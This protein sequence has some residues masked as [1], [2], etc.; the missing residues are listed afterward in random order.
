[1]F[2]LVGMMGACRKKREK[3][4]CLLHGPLFVG[5]GIKL[6]A[7]CCWVT[8]GDFP[9]DSALLWVGNIMT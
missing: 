6:D 2:G 4:G 8:L 1:M 3:R 9:H 7:H 5:E